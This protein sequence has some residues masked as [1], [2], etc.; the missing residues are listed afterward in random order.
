MK[1]QLQ[2]VIR[3]NRRSGDLIQIARKVEKEKVCQSYQEATSPDSSQSALTDEERFE[4]EWFDQMIKFFLERTGSHATDLERY[5]LFLPEKLYQIMQTLS[6][7][8]KEHNIDYRPMDSMMKSIINKIKATEVK[9]YEK[10]KERLDLLDEI[11]YI[12]PKIEYDKNK[13]DA[14]FIFK[15]LIEI[16][17]FFEAFNRIAEKKYHK[18]STAKAIHF[19]GYAQA[20]HL[21][22]KW[23]YSCA[24]DVIAEHK[25]P[26]TVTNEEALYIL[27]VKSSLRAGTSKQ[28]L[29]DLMKTWSATD[30]LLDKTNHYNGEILEN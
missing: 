22:P 18:S 8:C 24:I 12:E 25:S 7:K 29:I 6:V 26:L 16:P 13:E 3:K 9:L 20:L 4:I 5:R 11:N 21:P 19:K 23:V 28:E 17:N 10:T 15:A 14:K 1:E 30:E 27:W 2:I